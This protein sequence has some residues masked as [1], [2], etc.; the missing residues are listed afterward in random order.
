MSLLALIPSKPEEIYQEN[1]FKKN[2]LHLSLFAFKDES[3][4]MNE[5]IVFLVN[6][7]VSKVFSKTSYFKKPQASI[8]KIDCFGRAD[9]KYDVVLVDAY[10]IYKIQMDLQE[11]FSKNNVKYDQEF[12]F[13]PH[14]SLRKNSD[15]NILVPEDISFKEIVFWIN[16]KPIF[17]WK[18]K[19]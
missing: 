7:Y 2:K 5:E 3:P 1:G 4:S 17:K 19:S 8:T 18:I 16:E 12:S 10:W 14:I 9:K 13:R 15:E 11:I 6:H